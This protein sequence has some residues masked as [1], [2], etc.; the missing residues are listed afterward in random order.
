MKK[1]AISDI[2]GCAKTFKALLKKINFSKEDEL[3]ILG[4]YFDR[5]PDAKGVIDHIWKLQEEGHSVKCLLG[6]HEVMLIMAIKD[7]SMYN[8]TYEGVCKNFGIQ[9]VSEIPKKYQ[10]WIKTLHL[11]M[12]VDE[13]LLVHA[14][15]N[16][17]GKTPF[18]DLEAM[19]WIRHWYDD[20][21]REWLGDRLIIHGHT[22]TRYLEIKNSLKTLDD[23]PAIDIDAG[24]VYGA[25][26]LGHLCAFEMTE[27][28][29]TFMARVDELEG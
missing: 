1:Y 19:P 9:H 22:P 20:I 29:F 13:Y 6:N 14:G 3:Y 11:Y 18:S 26:G 28:E 5:G 4:D 25:F 2:H 15:F 16:F 23:I 7:Q 8:V 17:K 12:E 21:D 24:C 10:E 27:R